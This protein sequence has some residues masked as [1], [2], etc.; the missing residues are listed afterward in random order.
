MATSGINAFFFTETRGNGDFR[1]GNM[2]AF[3]E[4]HLIAI[5]R[6]SVV[7]TAQ[8]SALGLFCIL[9]MDTGN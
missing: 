2:T 3:R 6:F 8:D 9:P 5:F 1:P 4:S 7:T